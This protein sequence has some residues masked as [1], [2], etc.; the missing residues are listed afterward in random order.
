M[1]KAA[2]MA[3]TKHKYPAYQLAG[4]LRAKYPKM[5][6]RVS[7]KGIKKICTPCEA[8][9]IGDKYYLVDFYSMAEIYKKRHELRK[10]YAH[11]KWNKENINEDNNRL[12]F[13]TDRRAGNR[14]YRS[15]CN[16][17]YG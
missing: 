1:S 9:H 2:Q 3:Y 6:W 12:S 8:H 13:N 17:F 4:I 14:S 15:V 10:I 11:K 5:F 16:R 7:D